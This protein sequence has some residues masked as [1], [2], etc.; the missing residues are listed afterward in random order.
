MEIRTETADH[1]LK[2]RADR[3]DLANNRS[4]TVSYEITAPRRLNV[5]CLSDYGSLNAALLRGTVKGKTS[6]GSIK[7][8]GIE[9]PL[10]L[11]TSYGSIDCRSIAG[12][13]VL[14]RSRSGSITATV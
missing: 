9:G 1:G 12:P 5:L 11:D 14:L 3:P 6:S 10:D 8:E 4:I 2:I 13:T 7:A